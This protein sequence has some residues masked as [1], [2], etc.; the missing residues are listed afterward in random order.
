MIRLLGGMALLVLADYLY[1]AGRHWLAIASLGLACWLVL[2]A[3]DP[4]DSPPPIR[5]RW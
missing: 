4:G 1:G 3:A 5:Q 2:T